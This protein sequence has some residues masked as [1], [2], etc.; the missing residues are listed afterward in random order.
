MAG[1]WVARWIHVS[2]L[3]TR[4]PYFSNND[5]TM[6]N[7]MATENWVNI[8][9]GNGLL[10]DGTKPLPE[11]M[12]RSFSVHVRTISQ[13]ILPPS[14][15]KICLKINSLKFIS[16]PLGANKLNFQHLILTCLNL[17]IFLK[18]RNSA[19]GNISGRSVVCFDVEAQFNI[20]SPNIF[21]GHFRLGSFHIFNILKLSPWPLCL[22]LA[23]PLHLLHK[24]LNLF[25]HA[26]RREPNSSW[27]GGVWP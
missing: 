13:E 9:S 25:L 23:T 12:F 17:H 24:R 8:G 4:R 19:I 7:H 22:L 11:P 6:I 18:H 14:I 3:A 26:R 15:T 16:N 20:S 21:H 5:L 2:H 27:N 1:P 10:P